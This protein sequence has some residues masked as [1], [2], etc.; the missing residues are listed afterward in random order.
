MI[1]FHADDYGLF[2]QQSQRILDCAETGVLNGV[3][4]MPNSPHL[5]V[6]MDML[7]AVKKNIALTVHLNLVEGHCLSDPKDVSLLVDS[8]GNFNISF[9]KLL[10]KSFL[11][12]KLQ[13]KH[14]IKLELRKQI[15]R[16]LPYFSSS[17]LRLD[18]HVHYQ[19]IP[20][21][22]DCIMEIIQE[23]HLNVS[24]VR[25]PS[26]HL[27]WYF[28]AGHLAAFR[29]I[30]LIKVMVLNFFDSFS[31]RKYREEL[32]HMEQRDFFGVAYSGNM[33]HK[34][35][36][37]LLA[38]YAKGKKHAPNGAEMLFHP[39]SVLEPDCISQLTSADD[40]HFLTSEGRAAEAE[41]LMKLSAVTE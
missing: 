17:P 32:S 27:R 11:P 13:Y 41:A 33:C 9:E 3:S 22:F 25:V 8:K 39:G 28:S 19:G 31:R 24:Y 36:R 7:N 26:D 21:V 38:S 18:C 1:E 16:C 5:D 30:N 23:D 29:P 4:I 15:R 34:H 37:L 35:A 12:G 2:P 40:L 14:Q 10:I 20:L 6:C